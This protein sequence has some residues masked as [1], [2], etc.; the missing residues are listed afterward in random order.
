MD[1]DLVRDGKA[2]RLQSV[3]RRSGSLVVVTVGFVERD[4]GSLVIAAGDRE[5]DWALNLL[6]DPACR[7]TL[8]GA[9]FAAAARELEGT[10]RNA[11]IRDLI[12]RYGTPSER[13]GSGPAF[14]LQP[15]ETPPSDAS[16]RSR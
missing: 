7:V 2:I 1:D 13:L 3:G 16:R 15:V 11:A 12:L 8:R 6:A 14:E 10:E 5:A 4:D 9:T